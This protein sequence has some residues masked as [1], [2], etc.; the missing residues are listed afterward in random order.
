MRDLASRLR[1]IVR[2]DR[3]SQQDHGRERELVSADLPEFESAERRRVHAVGRVARRDA[4]RH[5]AGIAGRRRVPRHRSDVGPVAIARPA[6][7]HRLRDR[8]TAPVA[9]FDPRVAAVP[10]WASK[11]V[12]FDIET[13]GLSGGAGTIAFLAGIGWFDDDGFTVRQFLLAGPTGE[14]A[15]LESLERA[16]DEASVLVSYNG[17]TFDVP[18]ME[19]RWAF[20]RVSAPTDDLPHLDML[21]IARRLWGFKSG[22]GRTADVAESVS[23]SL[24]SLE[25]SVLDFHRVNDVP[26]FEIPAR[27]FHFVRTGDV[28]VIEGVLEHNRH[29]LVSLAVLTAHALWLADAGPEACREPRRADR[30]RAVLRARGRSGARRARVRAGGRVG[31]R[32]DPRARARASRGAAPRHWPHRRSGRSLAGDSR[33]MPTGA[34]SRLD[35][36]ERRAAEALA[37]YHEHRAKD[38]ATAKRY[39]ESLRR[40]STSAS[41]RQQDD[42]AHRLARLDRKIARTN[43]KGGPSAAPL[44]E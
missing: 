16:F 5:V 9:L 1:D 41:S 28:S 3:R 24:T 14:R 30:P 6:P 11:L 34:R 36:H 10:D 38:P 22:R 8:R 40:G 13:T 27:Y 15:L 43:S 26:G 25:R 29:D 42:V 35:R 19:M 2:Q 33:T 21:P 37:I 4:R 39:A 17:R 12:F 23:C 18:T 31:R 44:L 7:H 32:R 20:H